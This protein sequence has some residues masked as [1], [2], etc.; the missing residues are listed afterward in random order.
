MREYLLEKL[1]WSGGAQKSVWQDKVKALGT[2]FLSSLSPRFDAPKKENKVAY[3]DGLRG[4]AA[5]MVG[6]TILT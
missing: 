1:E 2:F 5:F 6:C 3:L 4:F